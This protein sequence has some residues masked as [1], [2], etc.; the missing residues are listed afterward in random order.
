MPGVV[1]GFLPRRRRE[2]V[3]SVTSKTG[4]AITIKGTSHDTVGAWAKRSRMATQ[5]S[6]NPR[7]IEP[8]SPIK[9]DAGFKFQNRK[10]RQAP[11]RIAASAPIN[12]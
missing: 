11:T 10:P 3:T 2:M 12:H 1:S 6:K 9:T 5:A 8:E 4:R 7:N